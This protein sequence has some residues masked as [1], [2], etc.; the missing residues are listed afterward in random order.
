M[1]YGT[2]TTGHTRDDLPNAR[3]IIMWGWN[4]AESIQITTTSNFMTQAKEAGV[5][6]IAIDPRFTDS[7]AA[8][9]SQWI[10]IRPGTDTAMLLAMAYVILKENLQDQNF[11]DTYTIGFERFRDY[12]M[13]I[14]DGV[15]KTASGQKNNGSTGRWHRAACQGLCHDK[16]GKAAN[17]WRS[18]THR[19]WRAVS[20]RCSNYC[21]HDRQYR[22]LWRRACQALVLRQSACSRLLRQRCCTAASPEI[23]RK[24]TTPKKGVHITKVWDAILKGTK[25]GYPADFKMVYTTNGNPVNQFMNSNKAVQALQSLEFFVVHEQF[26]TA[27]ARYADILL[28]VNTF[29]ERNDIVRPWHAAPYYILCKQSH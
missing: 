25:G 2:L 5:Q 16:T 27:T 26:M 4:P 15:P 20:P 1:T 11:L 23:C 7:A 13:G 21:G 19:V 12:V 8:F 9:A 29:F 3:L 18:G 17:A 24:R 14:S 22:H 28:P 6:I 10:P